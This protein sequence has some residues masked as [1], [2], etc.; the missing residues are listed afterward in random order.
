MKQVLERISSMSWWIRVPIGVAALLVLLKLS[1]SWLV[2]DLTD[3][4]S[5]EFDIAYE[6]SFYDWR[7]HFGTRD[8]VV[9]G[10]DDNGDPGAELAMDRL[11]VRPSSPLWLLR[12][13]F[14]GAGNRWVPD[15]IGLTFENFRET[16]ADEDTPGNHTSLPYDAMGCVAGLL[17]PRDIVAM[18]FPAPRRDVHLELDRQ[19]LDG[20]DATVTLDSPGL[21]RVSLRSNVEMQWP[22]RMKRVVEELMQAPVRSVTITIEDGGFIAARNAACAKKH[23]LDAEAFRAY[24]LQEVRRH[25]AQ[26]R[27]SYGEAAL[28]EYARFA[29]EGGSLVM[30]S[31]AQRNL[32]FGE[33]L[34]M[35]WGRKMASMPM[36]VAAN[37]KPPVAMY[38]SRTAR[39]VVAPGAELPVAAALPSPAEPVVVP[40]AGS[41]VTYDGA[42]GL[43]G[44]H[45]D[46]RTRH[47]SE[48]RGTLLVH[49][50]P[51][52]TMKLDQ[53][54]GGFTL[55]LNRQDVATIRFSPV[56]AVDGAAGSH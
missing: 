7:G 40:E 46:V 16:A 27:V 8:V 35:D 56:R 10:Y 3:V 23:G 42:A 52:I 44:E 53:A 34:F 1:V 50:P 49:S 15:S 30:N 2:E 28:A 43:V 19:S 18:G 13:V 14:T 25:M 20:V 38:F 4:I 26:H 11:V 21:G 12:S 24:H 48:R 31:T 55:T 36:Q 39:P 6:G 41:D 22:V 37:G 32:S 29:S 45:I 33:F 51:M 5:E 17:T 47:G 54:E 9:R